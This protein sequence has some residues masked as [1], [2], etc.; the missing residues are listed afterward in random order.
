MIFRRYKGQN[1]NFGQAEALNF[2]GHLRYQKVMDCNDFWI[3]C[4]PLNEE[5]FKTNFV[6]FRVKLKSYEF[7][8]R[9][10]CTSANPSVRLV[11]KSNFPKMPFW[12]ILSDPKSKLTI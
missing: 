3:C 6:S 5:N 7:F 11:Q 2:V 8:K 4:E 9:Q 1:R 12:L 10:E